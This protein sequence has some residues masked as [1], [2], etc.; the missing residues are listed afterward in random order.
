M[1]KV[2]V[3]ASPSL[4]PVDYECETYS[5]QAHYGYVL[6]KLVTKYRVEYDKKTNTYTH[7]PEKEEVIL[8]APGGSF[9]EVE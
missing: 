9:K 8:I 3:L 1:T 2:R 7:E 5:W 4:Y 6:L